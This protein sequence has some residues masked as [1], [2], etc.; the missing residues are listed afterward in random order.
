[1]TND[2]LLTLD[3]FGFAGPS[4]A[5]DDGVLLKWLEIGIQGLVLKWFESYIRASI[6]APLLFA[7]Y[8]L[9][10][11]PIFQKRYR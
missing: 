3:S 2:I 4:A 6:L 7:Q 5:F 9:P 11:G 8:L 10:L 1:M